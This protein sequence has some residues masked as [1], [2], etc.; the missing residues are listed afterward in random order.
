MFFVSFRF[1][2]VSQNPALVL[3]PF[4]PSSTLQRRGLQ[5]N[6]LWWW[7]CHGFVLSYMV[8]SVASETEELNFYLIFIIKQPCAVVATLLHSSALEH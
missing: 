2:S 7:K 3:C 5:C 6:F 1:V 8:P 4:G